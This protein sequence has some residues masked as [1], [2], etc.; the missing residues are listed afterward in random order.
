M[1]TVKDLQHHKRI[2]GTAPTLEDLLNLI[3]EDIIGCTG[4]E[5][6]D[7]DNEIIAEVTRPTMDSIED[8][9]VEEVE[10]VDGLNEPMQPKDALD[11]CKCMGKV[12]V[13]Y[14]NADG[15]SLLEIQKQL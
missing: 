12:C 4:L 13:D 1:N 3:E 8:K 2:C 10:E 6:P 15:V 11:L 14:A 9:E 7:G 5:F